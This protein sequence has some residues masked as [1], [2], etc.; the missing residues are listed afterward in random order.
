[1]DYHSR[2]KQT[3]QSLQRH[4]LDQLLVTHV[5]N[6][7]YLCGFTGSSGAL[8]VGERGATLFTDGRYT[9]QAKQEA[10]YARLRI[11]PGNAAAA[12]LASL[13][14]SRKHA[15]GLEG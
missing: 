10:P 12:A 9:V 6:V 7:R 4:R 2:I 5:P 8:L 15:V 13:K 3:Q 14:G 1:M 11:A